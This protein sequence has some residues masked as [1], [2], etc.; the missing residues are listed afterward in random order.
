MKTSNRKGFRG[1]MGARME[2]QR[3]TPQHIQ[4]LVM[5]DYCKTRNITYLLAATEYRMQGCTMILDAVLNELD[6]LE[7]IVMYSLM[8]FPQ[9]RAKRMEL[10]GKVLDKGCILHVAV[11]N[12]VIANWDD[13]MRIE[14][15]W[16]V[17]DVMAGQNPDI[18]N[19][20]K[21]WDGEHA[22]G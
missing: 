8:L 19:S 4:Q 1:Y 12:I 5:R 7:G 14:E 21:Q 9:T 20:L 13:A 17:H 2:M 22:T 16:L 6:A 3:S 10:Y 11:E 15:S 18:F